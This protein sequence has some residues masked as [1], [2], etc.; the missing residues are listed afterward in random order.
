MNQ[1]IIQTLFLFQ[2]FLCQF[3]QL[4]N[5]DDRKK[6]LESLVSSNYDLK[7]W[8]VKFTIVDFGDDDSYTR[9]G[10]LFRR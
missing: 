8:I 5:V 6:N 4:K 7:N 2:I 3:S 10:A 1:K 9:G